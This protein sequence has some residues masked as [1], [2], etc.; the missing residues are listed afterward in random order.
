ME[1]SKKQIV[2]GGYLYPKD[3]IELKPTNHFLER[4]S[5]RGLSL[6]CI[7]TVV[8]ITENNIHSGRTKMG[9]RLQSIVIKLKYTNTKYIF[10]CFNPFDHAAKTMWFRNIKN[11]NRS[12]K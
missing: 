5:E 8:R 4:L 11:D 3:F 6:N 10:I 9:N 1:L 2:E 12:Y 7:P